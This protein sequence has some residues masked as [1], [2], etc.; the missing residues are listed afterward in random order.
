M[1]EQTVDIKIAGNKASI[2]D[3]ILCERLT[4]RYPEGNILAVDRL[5]LMVH[6]G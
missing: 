3:V 5:D 6:S 1:N 4:K 2:D